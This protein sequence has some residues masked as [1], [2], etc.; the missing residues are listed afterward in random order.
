V[1]QRLSVTVLQIPEQT[2]ARA[3][4]T[5]VG[6][7]RTAQPSRSQLN[8]TAARID[9]RVMGAGYQA[10]LLLSAR[11]S[12]RLRVTPVHEADSCR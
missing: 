7:D 10:V 3:A 8:V 6:V 4:L 2:A 1:S 5:G 11:E 9:G 12:K